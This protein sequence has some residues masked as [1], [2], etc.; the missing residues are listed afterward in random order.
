MFSLFTGNHW[1]ST[2]NWSGFLVSPTIQYW[3]CRMGTKALYFLS[4]T[5]AS[6]PNRSRW[7]K[8]SNINDTSMDCVQSIFRPLIHFSGLDFTMARFSID[9]RHWSFGYDQRVPCE[10]QTYFG[11]TH[12]MK[13]CGWSPKS[14]KPPNTLQHI[15]ARRTGK[16]PCPF[17]L[18]SGRWK[19]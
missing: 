8:C 7:Q 4:W 16:N 12:A 6:W 17:H 2:P 1:F 11:G 10:L 19:N 5:L 14:Q 13:G 18:F 9:S 3:H 15:N